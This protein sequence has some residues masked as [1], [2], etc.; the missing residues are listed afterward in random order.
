MRRRDYAS[1][2]K[3]AVPAHDLG[4]DINRSDPLHLKKKALYLEIG[5]L[6]SYPYMHPR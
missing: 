6:R 1:S 5:V 2:V 4:S 3:A